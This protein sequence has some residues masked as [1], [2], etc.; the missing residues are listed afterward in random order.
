[1]ASPPPVSINPRT[2]SSL[3]SPGQAVLARSMRRAR[4]ARSRQVL[5]MAGST[6]S[7]MKSSAERALVALLV[8]VGCGEDLAAAQQ[9]LVAYKIV[10]DS[11]PASLT[12]S[13]GDAARGRAIVLSRQRG[14]C[15]LCH[16]GPFP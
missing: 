9:P 11:I 4:R 16:S 12:G 14:L 5:P 3:T 10:G 15:L 7:R 13:K 2:G 6:R 8:V 1:M